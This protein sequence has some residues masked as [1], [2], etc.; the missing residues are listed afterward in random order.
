MPLVGEKVAAGC[1]AGFLAPVMMGARRT[2]ARSHAPSLSVLV[3]ILLVTMVM[4]EGQE[5]EEGREGRKL[6][7]K[8]VRRKQP[9]PIGQCPQVRCSPGLRWE[10]QHIK[11]QD[12]RDHLSKI[13]S[14]DQNISGDSRGAGLREPGLL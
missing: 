2:M 3:T 8:K 1:L 13:T 7:L 5:E 12:T 10:W 4:V 11:F 6:V 9:Q 14:H